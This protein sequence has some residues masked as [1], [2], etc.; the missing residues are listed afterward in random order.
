MPPLSSAPIGGA[1]ASSGNWRWL[2]YLNLPIS[3]IAMALVL[4]FFRLKTPKTSFKE[5]MA[6]MDYAN[7]VSRECSVP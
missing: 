1:L 4:V 2:F 3:A 7:C 6:Q 5:K